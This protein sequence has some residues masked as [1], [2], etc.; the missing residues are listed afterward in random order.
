MGN[1][2][3]V[4]HH[5]WDAGASILVQTAALFC[6]PG[7]ASCCHPPPHRALALVSQ[8][9]HPPWSSH[10]DIYEPE[11]DTSDLPGASRT[12]CSLCVRSGLLLPS[13]LI[14]SQTS[15]V[16]LFL[17]QGCLSSFLSLL[18]KVLPSLPESLLA[19]LQVSDLNCSSWK[20]I[21]L[22]AQTENPPSPLLCRARGH[23]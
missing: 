11:Q 22:P 19:L 12:E 16:E 14:P 2:A 15:L 21:L 23:R 7:T 18:Q 3:H 4:G 1:V 17:A 10:D 9:K 20:P 8:T 13:L 5:W 6:Q